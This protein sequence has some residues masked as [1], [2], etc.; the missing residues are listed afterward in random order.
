MAVNFQSSV[1]APGSDPDSFQTTYRY[2]VAAFAAVATP[3]AM[4]II[5][6]SATKTVKIKQIRIEGVATAAGNMQIGIARWSTAGT[7][8]STG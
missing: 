8:T 4:V 1:I 7:A 5:Q 6:G 2:A 3:T